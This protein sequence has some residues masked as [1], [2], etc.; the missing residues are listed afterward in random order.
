MPKAEV[1][2]AGS[3]S[4]RRSEGRDLKQPRGEDTTRLDMRAA[5]VA[6]EEVWV[7]VAVHPDV[8]R[9]V[10]QRERIKLTKRLAELLVDSS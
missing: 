3:S 8:I 6:E 5:Q 1:M 10:R 4:G 9:A 2:S 7:N